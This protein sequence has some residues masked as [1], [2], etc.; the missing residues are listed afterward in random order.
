MVGIHGLLGVGK[1]TI[2]KAVYNIIDNC[3]D[4]SCF[5]ENVRENLGIDAGII[6]LQEQLLND[7]LGNGNWRVGSKFRGISLVKERLCRKKLSLILDDVDDL[8]RIENFLGKCNWFAPGSIIITL[9]DRHL[10][11][12]LKENVWTTSKVKE[13]KFEQLN[14]HEAIQLLKETWWRLF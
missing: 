13:F 2:T 10:L 8:T 6:K 12:A 7:I 4:W 3:F 5:L 11:A 14:E 9:R 1:T